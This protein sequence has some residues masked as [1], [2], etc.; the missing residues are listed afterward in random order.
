MSGEVVVG[1][2]GF[3]V[4]EAIRMAATN[5]AAAEKKVRPVF[6]DQPSTSALIESQGFKAGT[7]WSLVRCNQ[8]QN[9]VWVKTAA[10][11]LQNALPDATH[12]AK[13]PAWAALLS[14]EG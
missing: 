12:S 2:A 14:N 9:P 11:Q 3:V 13:I 7:R 8:S 5:Q 4:A 6:C 10:L 1:C